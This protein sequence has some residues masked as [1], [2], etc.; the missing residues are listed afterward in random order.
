[1]TNFQ[2]LKSNIRSCV[3]QN[4][5]ASK[6]RILKNIAFAILVAALAGC[7]EKIDVNLDQQQYTRLV[8]DARFSS[9]T[10]AHLVKLS[11]TADYFDNQPP[12][13]VSGAEVTIS[14]AEEK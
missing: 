7:T 3:W 12:K 4:T 10:A 1:M 2:M 5:S 9:D 6:T 8:V 11:T 14:N 13:R